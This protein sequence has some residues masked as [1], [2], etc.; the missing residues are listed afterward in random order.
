[1]RPSSGSPRNSLARPDLPRPACRVRLVCGPPASGKSTYVKEHKAPGDVVIDYDAIARELGYGR[2]RPR[3]S[4]EP[5]LRERN[6][7]LAALANAP[8]SATAWVI[9]SAASRHL[10]AWWCEALGVVPCDLAVLVPSRAELRRRIFADDDRPGL[11]FKMMQM[12]VVDRWFAMEQ[13]NSPGVIRS[14]CSDDGSP[15]DPL[16]H[17][18]R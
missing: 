8:S 7:R 2:D 15:S 9:V 4:I 10:R 13:L 1:L 16:H 5:I 11:R 12:E 18:N 14:G 6:R 3:S 17:W